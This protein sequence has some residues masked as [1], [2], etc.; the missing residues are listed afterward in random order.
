MAKRIGLFKNICQNK[1][2]FISVRK[3][4]MET[5]NEKTTYSK[6]TN[7]LRWTLGKYFWRIFHNI[8]FMS[9]EKTFIVWEEKNSYAPILKLCMIS[10]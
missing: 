7:V 6:V 8:T 10:L 5:N 1:F 4:T 3:W 9:V 2:I